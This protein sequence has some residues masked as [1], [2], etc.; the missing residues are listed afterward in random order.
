[1]FQLTDFDGLCLLKERATYAKV[2]EK[3]GIKVP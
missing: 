2:I 3:A 1:L